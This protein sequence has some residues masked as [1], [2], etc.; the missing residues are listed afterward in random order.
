MKQA[1][2]VSWLMLTSTLFTPAAAWE[3]QNGNYFLLKVG[4]SGSFIEECVVTYQQWSDVLIFSYTRTN[5]YGEIVER[6]EIRYRRSATSHRFRPSHNR[7]SVASLY[8]ICPGI[9]DLAKALLR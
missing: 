1:V 5:N 4:P 3:K 2:L 8:T 6:R 7:H 9:S